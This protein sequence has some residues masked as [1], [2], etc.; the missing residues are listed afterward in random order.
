MQGLPLKCNNE[1]TKDPQ[2]PE[3]DGEIP[4]EIEG[5]TD[6]EETQNIWDAATDVPNRTTLSGAIKSIKGV[7]WGK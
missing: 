6:F 4:K 5:D 1:E 7:T 3:N 2:T